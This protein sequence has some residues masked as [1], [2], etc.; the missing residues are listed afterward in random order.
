MYKSIREALGRAFRTVINVPS[1]GDNESLLER[2]EG[3]EETQDSLTRAVLGLSEGL[4]QLDDSLKE[5]REDIGYTQDLVDENLFDD[6]RK[7]GEKREIF[8]Y[9]PTKDYSHVKTNHINLADR[10]VA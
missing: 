3:A 6:K 7:R 4:A 5:A 1:I 9:D 8:H 2:I 10:E